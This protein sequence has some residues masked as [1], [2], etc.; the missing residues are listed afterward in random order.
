MHLRALSKFSRGRKHFNVSAMQLIQ[1]RLTSPE[2][3]QN[4]VENVVMHQAWCNASSI[5]TFMT[6][7]VIR[8]TKYIEF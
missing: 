1:Q 6:S 3:G 4:A 8:A 2:H 7:D 5:T